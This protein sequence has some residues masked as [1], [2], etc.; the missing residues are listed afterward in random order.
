MQIDTMILLLI[1][2]IFLMVTVFNR[3]TRNFLWFIKFIIDYFFYYKE[4]DLDLAIRRGDI[5]T[6]KDLI[7]SGVNIN[8]KNSLGDTPLITATLCGHINIIKKLIKSGVNINKKN[9]LGDTPL[10]LAKRLAGNGEVGSFS[11]LFHEL[12]PE[13]RDKKQNLNWTKK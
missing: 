10:N 6:V 7:K 9:S 5:D 2:I 11:V 8:K 13:Y 1:L 4:T 3:F 12:Y